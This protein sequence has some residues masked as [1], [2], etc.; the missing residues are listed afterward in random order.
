MMRF[1]ILIVSIL[2]T[3][4]AINVNSIYVLFYLCSD[5]V[6][7]ILF[8]QLLCVIHV[9][10]TNTYGSAAG[11]ILG[12]V[13]RLT[14]GEPLLGL[15]TAIKYPNWYVGDGQT[16]QLFPFKTMSMLISLLTIIIVSLLIKCLFESETLS[17]H[18]DIFKAFEF[19]NEDGENHVVAKGIENPMFESVEKGQQPVSLV[20]LTKKD[21]F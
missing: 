4:I 18:A 8:P 20:M 21:G 6:Y 1:A 14:G 11:Y 10:F 7:V 15:P 19:N 2:A 3:V 13:F 9:D 16:Y 17:K 12:W 5:L